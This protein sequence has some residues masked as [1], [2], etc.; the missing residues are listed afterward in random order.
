MQIRVKFTTPDAFHTI[1]PAAR[2]QAEEEWPRL[3]QATKDEWFGDAE[4]WISGRA[5]EL[6][7]QMIAAM[8]DW[9]TDR[10]EI[11]VQFTVGGSAQ[12]IMRKNPNA[13]EKRSVP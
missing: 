9:V 7:N 2:K 13:K 3:P 11:T 8:E 12:L 5:G 4:N 10:H 1:G 6:M